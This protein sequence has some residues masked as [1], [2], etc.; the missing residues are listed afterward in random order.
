MFSWLSLGRPRNDDK[1]LLISLRKEAAEAMLEAILNNRIKP[2]QEIILPATH[3]DRTRHY[4]FG[5]K[6]EGR[7][8]Y[9]VFDYRETRSITTMVQFTVRLE[10]KG[11]HFRKAHTDLMSRYPQDDHQAIRDALLLWQGKQHTH[12]VTA[13]LSAG[14][15]QPA[16]A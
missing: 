10:F 1:A 5:W 6:V 13:P 11:P 8:H 14:L 4:S 12:P 16:M 2:F 7:R 9:A 3:M 15:A